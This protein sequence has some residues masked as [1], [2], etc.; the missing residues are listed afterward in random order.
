[1]R[2]VGF[3]RDQ[4]P[5]ILIRKPAAIADPMTPATLGPMACMSRKLEGF[6]FWPSRWDTRADAGG[7]RHRGHAGGANQRI[8]LSAAQLV[9]QL[10]DQQAADG[11]EGE[12]DQAQHNDLDGVELQEPGSDHRGADAD[13]QEQG[14]D[15]HQGVLGHV[16]QAL[17]HAG[18]L[19]QVAEHQA[20][21]QGRGGGQQQ[22]D[23]D[24][25]H[26][27]EQD[28]LGGSSRSC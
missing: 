11:A 23:E 12:R 25:D 22:D 14:D 10:A 24:R 4:P 21:D 7:H 27:R 8:D 16:A 26:D 2:S 15:I 3:S 17:G 18:F 28:L 19:E 20:A 5:N 13:A 6:A 9:H 1:M